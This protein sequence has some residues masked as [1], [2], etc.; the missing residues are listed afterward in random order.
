MR[1]FGINLTVFACL[2]VLITQARADSWIVG[3]PVIAAAAASAV[4]LASDRR[5]RWSIIGFLRFVPH[6][7]RSSL[8][9]GIDV[10]WRSLHPQLP[11]HP[12][13]VEY[14][15]HLPDGTARIFFMNIINLLPGTVSADIR[16]DVLTI[17]VI[18]IRQPIR[19]QLE[20]LEQKVAELFATRIETASGKGEVRS[21]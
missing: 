4:Y 5:W 21:S 13:L 10:A 11:I 14:P 19:Q 7:A 17:H 12:Q 8:Y 6:F 1:R 16:E 9:G 20:K 18:D 2:W 15:L 3:V